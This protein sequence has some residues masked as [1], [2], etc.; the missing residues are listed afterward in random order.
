[1]L[2]LV[3]Q[4]S[5]DAM[6][7]LITDRV[8]DMRLRFAE[9]F[10][11]EL[12]TAQAVDHHHTASADLHRVPDGRQELIRIHFDRIDANDR[13]RAGSDHIIDRRADARLRAVM[14]LAGSS[15][16]KSVARARRA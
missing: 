11:R 3:D 15:N 13:Q 1:M 12:I 14:K 9:F 10:H 5:R 8:V 6:A 2:D 4:Q 16:V 7:R